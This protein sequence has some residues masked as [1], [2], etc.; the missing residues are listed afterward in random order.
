LF[1]RDRQKNKEGREFDITQLG[2][3][4]AEK[5]GDDGNSR[6]IREDASSEIKTCR[7]SEWRL[8]GFISV[9]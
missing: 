9:A 8:Q 7:R 2:G 6:G 1:D 5:D 3:V 4:D